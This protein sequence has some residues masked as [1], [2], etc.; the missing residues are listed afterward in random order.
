MRS[1]EKKKNY[2][3]L[4]KIK[5]DAFV[6]FDMDD[7]I[8]ETNN[9][10]DDMLGYS[11]G[12]LHNRSYRDITPVRWHSIEKSIIEEQ[13]L[14]HG[15]SNIYEKEYIRKDGTVFPVE[16]RTVLI[17]DDYNQAAGIRSFARDITE[18]KEA[19]KQTEENNRILSLLNSYT[20]EQAGVDSYESLVELIIEQLKGCSDAILVT[21]SEYNPQKKA[22]ISR[23]VNSDHK[24]ASKAVG[25]WGKDIL[26]I[27]TPVSDQMYSD[28]ISSVIGFRSTLSDSTQGT[29][30]DT[31]S[32]AIQ[33]LLGMNCFVG[34][35][36][37]VEGELYGTSMIGIKDEQAAPPVDFLES[38]AFVTAISLR[39]LKA[40]ERMRYLS[41]HDDL[42]GLY[43]R[44]FLEAAM[45]RLDT[46]R[47][48][49]IS[50]VM[51]D[52][53]GLKL[54]NDTYGHN[55]GDLMLQRAAEILRNS[56]RAEDII[57]RWGGDEIVIC[58]PQ[59][60]DKT[61]QIILHRI[62]KQCSRVYIEDVPLSM[63]LGLAV[64]DDPA[65]NIFTVFKEAEDNM[66][67]NK[68]TE[69][70]SGKSSTVKALLKTLADKSFET[71]VHTQRMQE[72]AL[73]IGENLGLVD[74]EL[75]RLNL[76]ISLHDIGKVNIPEELLVKK[77]ELTNKE[78]QII[79]EHPE[80]GFRIARATEEF[81]HV[82][83]DI[84]AHHEKWDGSGYPHGLKGEEIPLLARITS[85]A[86]AYEVMSSGRPYKKALS[87]GDIAAEFNKCA[88]SH[89]DPKLVDIFLK[90]PIIT[91][92]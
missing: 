58:L 18:R 39:R 61:A 53:N 68:L 17:R 54:V 27:E 5:M 11:P 84:L 42:T 71:E 80:T 79:K 73:L 10:F 21:F 66:Y 28:I 22:L 67:K 49:P 13:V 30:P 59:T 65:K 48:L 35:A 63:A 8:L 25:I 16:L 14:P 55:T 60:D 90:L 44:H 46:E 32:S 52:L 69:S 7:R 37:V 56:F 51:A 76:L 91:K 41:W 78:W 81:A 1:S 74:S 70:R 87:P 15:F 88:G 43:N 92:I 3:Q 4:P 19:E 45:Q 72:T 50:I 36:H 47:Q 89:F 31:I 75:K 20:I 34:L 57:S 83:E 62:K 26:N 33:K 29:I 82:A 23:N 40:E 85:V 86:D 9:F 24:L 38:Y 64:K 77:E 6:H 12:E 2:S